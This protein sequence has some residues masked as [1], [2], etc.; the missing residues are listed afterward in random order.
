MSLKSPSAELRTRRTSIGIYGE[1]LRA[2][3]SALIF[4]P[5]KL[6]I[7]LLSDPLTNRTAPVHPLFITLSSLRA[8]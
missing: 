1:L 2:K 5:Q 3:R 7:Q 4:I 6:P 8:L